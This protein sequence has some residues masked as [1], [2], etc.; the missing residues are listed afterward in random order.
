MI[1][2]SY[3]KVVSVL[4]SVRFIVQMVAF[5]YGDIQF[6]GAEVDDCGML[7]DYDSYSILQVESIAKPLG[8][9]IY[10]LN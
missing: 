4:K 3:E 8:I 6:W 5:D 7:V 9:D 10:K 1:I 2:F